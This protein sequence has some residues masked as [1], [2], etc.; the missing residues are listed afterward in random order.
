MSDLPPLLPPLLIDQKIDPR[1]YAALLY[2]QGFGFAAIA[3]ILPV[4][5]NTLYS[6]RRRDKWDDKAPMARIET[7]LEDRYLRLTSKKV[8]TEKDFKEADFL[9]RQIEKARR[10]GGVVEPSNGG[11]LP[12]VSL[13]KKGGD[14]DVVAAAEKCKE[15]FFDELFDYQRVWYE[16]GLKHRIRNILK[17]RQIGAT[18]FFAR[19]ALLDALTTGRNQIFLSASRAQAHEFKKY[20]A[21][22]LLAATGITLKGEF[23]L[24]PNGATLYFL[25]TSSK[26]AQSYHG[27][28][29]FDEYFYVCQFSALRR[30]ASGMAAHKRW[31]QTFF[32]TP[33]TLDH[34]AYQFWSG[35]SFNRGRA[36]S[37][38]ISLDVS[39]KALSGGVLGGDSVWRQMVTVKDALNGG[40]DLFDLAQ[41]Q[42]EYSPDEFANLFMC[43]FM[44]DSSAAFGFAALQRCLCDSWADWSDFKPLHERPLAGKPVWIGYDC[45]TTGDNSALAV[46]APP[47]KAGGAFRLVDKRV[48]KEAAYEKQD[49]ILREV[50]Q[51]FNVEHI[52]IDTTGGYGYAV[53]ELVKK[54]FPRVKSLRYDLNS[55]VRLVLKA[56]SVINNGRFLFDSKESDVT[57]AFL[58]IKKELT[59]S[60]RF[61]TFKA[62]RGEDV[63]HSDIAWAIMNALEN[64]PLDGDLNKQNSTVFF[65]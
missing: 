8:L 10:I 17:S 59:A 15:A 21:A 33:S 46:I 34:E 45:A 63:S 30:V 22:F 1:R 9:L 19:E 58:N 3:E 14:F 24:L 28:L 7:S 60:K 27:N 12:V 37:D 6:W 41:L 47:D 23:P 49:E 4:N 29:Y 61:M 25:G 57:R 26:T 64:E 39:H 5:I 16:A 42:N 38:C 40:C 31:R 51:R 53:H 20:I 43:E 52:A 36:K 65:G 54:W 18:W 56:Q 32:S 2:W 50:A 62:G 11:A 35:K 13:L 44:D 48:F 55:K